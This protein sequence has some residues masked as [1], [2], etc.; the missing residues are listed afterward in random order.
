MSN[1]KTV[2]YYHITCEF[3]SESTLYSSC[4]FR[5]FSPHMGEN[6]HVNTV[7]CTM[8]CD[9]YFFFPKTLWIYQRDYAHKHSIFKKPKTNVFLLHLL[10]RSNICNTTDVTLF[11]E[12]RSK[13]WKR[14]CPNSY[15]RYIKLKESRSHY[16]SIHS[17]RF[18]LR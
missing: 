17:W 13:V 6:A 5:R 8:V 16:F 7:R 9:V 3:Q 4:P 2:C 18:F 15:I 12:V 11:N 14:N 1:V 10:T